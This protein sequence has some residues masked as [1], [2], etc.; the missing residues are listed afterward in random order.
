MGVPYHAIKR[1][2]AGPVIQCH[3]FR[4][5]GNGHDQPF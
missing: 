4:T 1:E 2:I 3:S 5:D